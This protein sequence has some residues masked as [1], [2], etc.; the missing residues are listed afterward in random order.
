[1]LKAHSLKE[2]RLAALDLNHC[3]AMAT[4][5]EKQKNTSGNLVFYLDHYL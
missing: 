4:R 2:S 1:M 5:Y 3:L